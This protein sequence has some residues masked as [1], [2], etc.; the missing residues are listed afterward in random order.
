[1]F[2][3]HEKLGHFAIFYV[4]EALVLAVVIKMA[5]DADGWTAV[6]C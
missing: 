2:T 6:M 4:D 1:M 3:A 5:S